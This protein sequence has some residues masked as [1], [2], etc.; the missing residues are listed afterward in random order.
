MAPGQRVTVSEMVQAKEA[1]SSDNFGYMTMS[2]RL[3]D[4]NPGFLMT[5][6]E[7]EMGREAKNPEAAAASDEEYQV[8]DCTPAVESFLQRLQSTPK[9]R[10]RSSRWLF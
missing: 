6:P 2:M 3:I 1:E 7:R 8:V 9:F 5:N 10:K 4:S